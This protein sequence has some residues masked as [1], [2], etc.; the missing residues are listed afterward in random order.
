MQ[1]V[2]VKTVIYS[3][4][5]QWS[6]LGQTVR[7]L[8]EDALTRQAAYDPQRIIRQVLT[9]QVNQYQQSLWQ[10]SQG[11]YQHLESPDGISKEAIHTFLDQTVGASLATLSQLSREAQRLHHNRIVPEAG[12]F[13]R[14]AMA[15][16]TGNN[17]Q[18]G[19]VYRGFLPLDTTGPDS[20]HLQLPP[21]ES[22]CLLDA[23]NPLA[24]SSLVENAVTSWAT[25]K[26]DGAALT[27]LQRSVVSQGA[28]L[29]LLG[30]AYYFE[31]IINALLTNDSD[32]ITVVEP[33]LFHGIQRFNVSDK[34]VVILHE[35]CERYRQAVSEPSTTLPLTEDTVTQIYRLVEQGIP[36]TTAFRAKSFQ[37][38]LSVQGR[39]SAGTLLSASTVYPKAEVHERLQAQLAAEH[40]ENRLT[41]DEPPSRYEIYEG[42]RFVAEAPNTPRE[43]V[44]AG[45]I[46]TFNQIPLV[47]FDYFSLPNGLSAFNQHIAQQDTLLMK[48][49]ETAEVHRM[50]QQP[51]AV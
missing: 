48:S 6:R 8:D 47:L 5:A 18:T 45:W 24:W 27:P 13:R 2:L 15:H 22:L 38:S 16:F 35:V 37:R 9:S 3:L 28:M 7:R 23:E 40:P 36:E 46:H 49:I 34:A 19:I 39:L 44:N 33:F 41:D 12:M 50:L 30:P 1:K 14:E 43:I 42:L 31:R 17:D 25:P 29:R 4:L 32:Y 26:A 51:V 20:P 11:L 21:I 10:L